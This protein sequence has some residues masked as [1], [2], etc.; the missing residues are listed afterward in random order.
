[1]KKV[2]AAQSY[3]WANYV[4][5]FANYET[6]PKHVEHVRLS[7]NLNGNS[8]TVLVLPD[9][10]WHGVE[11]EYS[12]EISL[13]KTP[14]H[15]ALL[16]IASRGTWTGGANYAGYIFGKEGAKVLFNRKGQHKWLVF[17]KDGVTY[18]YDDPDI[19]PVVA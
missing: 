14:A 3:K 11:I 12:G 19:V 6:C 9:G 18:E 4:V 13:W 1:M 17:G 15:N 10:V 8:M 7:T 16:A 5:D 2:Y